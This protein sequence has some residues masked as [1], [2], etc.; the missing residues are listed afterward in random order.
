MDD[1]PDLSCEDG[2]AR[3]PLDGWEATHNWLVPDSTRWMQGCSSVG[4]SRR[5]ITAG[6]QVRGL[7]APPSKS[8]KPCA[9]CRW[10]GSLVILLVIPRCGRTMGGPANCSY[11][12]DSHRM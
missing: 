7:P 6:S 8:R 10:V 1:T 5:L 11:H 3:D 4:Q 12:G 2:T 9:S